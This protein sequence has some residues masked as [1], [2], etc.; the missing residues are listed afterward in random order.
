[1]KWTQDINDIADIGI[2][3]MIPLEEGKSHSVNIEHCFA[4][5][6]LRVFMKFCTGADYRA[7]PDREKTICR[8]VSAGSAAVGE[9]V[10]FDLPMWTIFP[11]VRLIDKAVAEVSKEFRFAVKNRQEQLARGEN[12][13]TDDCLSAM[14]REDMSEKDMEEH[15]ITLICAGHDTSAY[16]NSYLV[17]LL[18][19]HPEVQDK[20]RAEVL[21]YFQGRTHVTPDDIVQLEYLAKVMQETLRFYAIIPIVSRT[22]AQE[23][24]IKEGNVTIPKGVEMLIPVAIMNRDP[25]IWENPS[26][27]NPDRFE[28]KS[29][30]F[31]SAKNG[32]FPF[33]YGSR[34]CIGNTLAQ[35]ESGIFLCKLLMRMK[36]EEDPG[37]KIRILSGISLTTKGG[38]NVCCRPL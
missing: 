23:V 28:G 38:I 5:L 15:F 16:F 30:D 3:E 10:L 31:T 11:Q 14:L 9:C 7:M 26:V 1:M 4:S 35:I 17:Y 21:G 27:F 22:S 37:F 34:T 36:F 25:T 2:K 29:V 8:S 33:G 24:H 32:F 18:A 19:K 20:L 6:A 13:D 12:L